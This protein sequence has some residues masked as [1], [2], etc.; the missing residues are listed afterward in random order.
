MTE[1]KKHVIERRSCDLY[2]E[3]LKEEGFSV[4]KGI[5]GIETAFSA[6]FGKGRPFIGILAEYDALSGLSPKR[7]IAEKKTGSIMQY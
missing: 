5:C 3:L 7:G 4:S 1:E 2:C 6:S